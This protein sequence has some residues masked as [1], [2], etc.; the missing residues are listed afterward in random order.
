MLR[1]IHSICSKPAIILPIVGMFTFVSCQKNQVV[2]DIAE[3]ANPISSQLARHGDNYT[4]EQL[5][6][7]ILLA[8]G[9]V[10]DEIPLLEDMTISN[11]TTDAEFI[12]AVSNFNSEI[13]NEINVENPTFFAEFKTAMQSGKHIDIQNSL[14]NAKEV[15]MNV[16]KKLQVQNNVTQAQLDSASQIAQVIA[17]DVAN[18][19][20]T[21]D[22]ASGKT[23]L[24]DVMIKVQNATPSTAGAGAPFFYKV[25]YIWLQ[26]FL[27]VYFFVFIDAFLLLLLFF[28][29]LARGSQDAIDKI[30]TLLGE[31][32]IHQ[33]AT[34]LK[35][36]KD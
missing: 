24:K 31:R 17:R 9:P 14:L 7:G 13:V 3:K 27:F 5:F 30:N 36:K 34:N 22:I 19:I 29:L 2:A 20:N 10:V 25:N 35:V 15:L 12:K 23:K 21:G 28:P 1:K 16:M 11:F 32:F 26:N 6:K 8:E 33:I 18:D 4:G